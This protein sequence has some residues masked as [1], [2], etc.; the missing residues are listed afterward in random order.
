MSTGIWVNDYPLDAVGF[1]LMPGTVG[2]QDGGSRKYPTIAIPGYAG[3]LRTGLPAVDSRVITCKGF[4]DRQASQAQ[5]VQIVDAVKA[6]CGAG[7]NEVRFVDKTDRTFLAD[8]TDAKVAGGTVQ[9]LDTYRT[10]ELTFTANLPA[11]F[12]QAG[13]TTAFSATPA[14]LFPGSAPIVP[15]LR[16]FA[17]A[18]LATNPTI[19]YRDLAGN[20]RGQLALTQVLATTDYLEINLDTKVISRSLSG[21]I[22]GPVPIASGDFFAIDPAD[23]DRVNGIGPTI[24]VTA[25]AGTPTGVAY[26][27]RMWQ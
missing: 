13:R 16:I 18:G 21:V 5:A 4:V 17:N 20:I 9:F 19:T 15:V 26:Y 2:W 12:D 24:E 1:L 11:G 10:I 7:T 14:N 23:G 22:S 27:R 25:S 6:I 3:L 8:L